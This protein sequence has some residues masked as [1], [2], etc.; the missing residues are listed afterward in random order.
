MDERALKLAPGLLV[1][2]AGDGAQVWQPQRRTLTALDADLLALLTRFGEGRTIADAA[3]AAG[4][5]A[6]ESVVA[7]VESF[8]A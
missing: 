4:L 5:E 1:S 8:V 7:A 2:L 3:A 6:D